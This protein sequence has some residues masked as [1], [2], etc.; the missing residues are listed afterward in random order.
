VTA[1]A[2]GLISVGV[3]SA[4]SQ[5]REPQGAGEL[6]EPPD[7][8]KLVATAGRSFPNYERA[9][10]QVLERELACGPLSLFAV[11]E[12]LGVEVPPETR[13][14]AVDRALVQGSTMRELKELAEDL[15]VYAAGVQISV[16]EL[17]RVEMPAV[18]LFDTSVF[19][20]VLGY[21]EGGL[22]IQYA[23]RAAAIVPQEAFSRHFGEVGRALLL[24]RSRI[25]SRLS[26][27]QREEADKTGLALSQEAVALG[28]LHSRK[29]NRDVVVANRGETEVVISAVASSC[30]CME[31]ALESDRLAPRASTTLAISGVEERE[32]VF[33]HEV[34]LA[35]EGGVLIRLPVSGYVDP[36]VYFDPP[37]VTIRGVLVGETARLKVPVQVAES[38]VSR[39]LLVQLPPDAPLRVDARSSGTRANFLEIEF[40][41]GKVAGWYTY[42]IQAGVPFQN[43]NGQGDAPEADVT[44]AKLLMA[45]EV[46]PRLEVFPQ[47]VWLRD[48]ELATSWTRTIR[49]NSRGEEATT[50]GAATWSDDRF[51]RAIDAQ[52]TQTTPRQADLQLSPKSGDLLPGLSG[53]SASLLLDCRGSQV[54]IPV[55]I[56]RDDWVADFDNS[57]D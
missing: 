32:G 18:A 49:V 1:V 26:P 45:V 43:A 40:T 17:Q 3:W 50:V 14:S 23:G 54:S 51:D 2:A 11:L 33:R 30:S 9:R 6:L 31:A 55:H 22:Q 57:P 10:R 37:A 44:N 35:T 7:I 42:E 48:D 47:A 39:S 20:A 4:V 16:E 27:T 28:V 8:E 21:P 41:G 53:S 19:V 25:E 12:S 15:G 34:K 29:W 13:Q 52:V 46:I 38:V 36:P 56:G 5:W 24:S